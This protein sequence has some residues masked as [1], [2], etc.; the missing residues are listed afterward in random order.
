MTIAATTVVIRFTIFPLQ[1]WGMHNT[2]KLSVRTN[3]ALPVLHL[4][5]PTPVSTQ[6]EE[7][8][9][10]LQVAK[11]DVEKAAQWYREECAVRLA[12]L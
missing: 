1:V 3:F 6:C 11:P 7:R 12:L 2:R 10:C 4:A 8:G 9:F 5:G